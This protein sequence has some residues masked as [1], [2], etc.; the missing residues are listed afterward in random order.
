MRKLLAG[1]VFSLGKERGNPLFMNVL[2]P[3]C[4]KKFRSGKLKENIP[5]RR[6]VQNTGV[7]DYSELGHLITQIQVLCLRRNPVQCV[8]R[9]LLPLS[10]ILLQI[11]ES[12]PTMRTHHV[13]RNV[14]S[15]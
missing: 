14:A 10:F 4:T 13:M 15:A 2:A 1:E 9:T 12:Y 11:F 6:W 8:S 5:Q 3:F 7:K